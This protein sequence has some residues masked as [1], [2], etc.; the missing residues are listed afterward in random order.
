MRMILFLQELL[1]DS[2]YL[3][4]E[5]YIIEFRCKVTAFLLYFLFRLNL[6]CR[7]LAC[8]RETICFSPLI[9]FLKPEIIK[10]TMGMGKDFINYS[11]ENCKVDSEENIL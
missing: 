10:I 8:H 4:F 7:T 11:N 2:T 3:I 9:L 6:H 1:C 5:F